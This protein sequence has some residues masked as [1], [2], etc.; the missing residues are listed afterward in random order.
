MTTW[1]DVAVLGF[2]ID[3]VGQYQLEELV[4][5]RRRTSATGT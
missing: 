5:K 1:A 3:R 4:G 2:L